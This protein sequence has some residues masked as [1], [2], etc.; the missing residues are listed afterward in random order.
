MSES[1]QKPIQFPVL[2]LTCAGCVKRATTAIE[3]VSGTHNVTVNLASERASVVVDDAHT[4]R[5]VHQSLKSA[6]YPAQTRRVQF[7]LV[8]MHCASCVQKVEKALLAQP[9]VIAARVNLATEEASVELLDGVTEPTV[10]M[11][12]IQGAGYT[13]RLQDTSSDAELD[14]H[15]ARELQGLKNSFWFALLLTLPVFILEMG[16]HFVPAVEQFIAQTIGQTINWNL[17]FVLT[18]LVLVFPGRRFYQIGIPALLKGSPDM[19]SLVALGTLA[20]WG[21]SVVATFLPGVLPAGTANVYYEA[22][23]VIVTLILLGRYLEARA[24]GRTGE[25]IK[26]LIGLQAQTAWVQR[27]NGS[28]TDYVEVEIS[29]ITPGD[30]VRVRPG[31]KIPLD[32][33]VVEGRSYVD[34]SMLTGEPLPVEKGQGD[35]VTGGTINSEGGLIVRVS[36][37]GADTVLAQIIQMVEQAQGTQL[38]V[39]ALVDKVTAVFV[40][41]V[42]G[43]ALFTVGVWAIFGPEPAL[44]F[45]LVNGV[46]VLIIACP[47]AMGLATPVSIMVGTGRAA[48]QGILFRQGE[49]LQTLRDCKVVALDKTGTLTNGKPELTDFVVVSDTYDNHTLLAMIASAEQGSEHPIAQAIVTAARERQLKL[50]NVSDFQAHAGHG[51]SAS[52]NEVK[53]HIGADR[54]MREL[55]VDVNPQQEVA[56]ELAQAGKTPM[57]AALN[58]ELVALMAVADTL[59]DGTKEAID[60]FHQAGLKV[61]MITGD[62]RRTAQVIASQLG[63]DEVVAEV[64]PDGK[65]DAVNALRERFG[66]IAFVGDGINDAPALA[67]ADTGI[68]V[69]SGTDIAIES[70]DVVL[71]RSD[72]RSVAAAISISHKTLRNIKQNLF[73]AFAYNASL[74]PVAAGVLYPWFGILLSPILAAGAMALSSI[75][76][77]TNALRLKRA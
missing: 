27:G 17:Q 34:E 43:I 24:K 60:A 23:A 11:Q 54:F 64:M 49:S 41:V 26:R 7:H 22:A 73:W 39:Q 31:D 53:V 71:M 36:A 63:I 15:K 35:A 6:G 29:E 20:A 16:S 1:K 55:G 67:Q 58:G 76:V 77:L 21:F 13:A 70:A 45:A 3:Q 68:A 56:L 2:K 61:A 12:V 47:C 46:A 42:I 75:F 18:T 32:G 69:G 48:E 74:I 28:A 9:G 59:R 66:A 4:A 10:L 72:L 62:N 51:V 40:P 65:V 44:T 30:V 25:A 5:E 38:P 19:N 33:Q 50:D 14:D 37:T 57:Y 8:G 52:I